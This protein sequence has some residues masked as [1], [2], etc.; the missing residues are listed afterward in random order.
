MELGTGLCPFRNRQFKKKSFDNKQTW[1]WHILA[2]FKILHLR[3]GLITDASKL[4]LIYIFS[5]LG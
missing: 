2:K 3:A 1:T 5:I 4:Y